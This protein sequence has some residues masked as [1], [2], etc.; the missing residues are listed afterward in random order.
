VT[1]NTL[2]TGI[3]R[4]S[5]VAHTPQGGA[6]QVVSGT[7]IYFSADAGSLSAVLAASE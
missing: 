1:W 7:E 4:L 3:V 2:D 6:T 5:P